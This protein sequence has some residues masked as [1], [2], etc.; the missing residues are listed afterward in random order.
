MDGVKEKDLRSVFETVKK[1]TKNVEV[2]AEKTE[3][4]KNDVIKRFETTEKAIE[5]AYRK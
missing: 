4:I 5:N 1:S 3:Q 2:T